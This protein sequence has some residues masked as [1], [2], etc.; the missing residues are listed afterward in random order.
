MYL[1]SSSSYS[2]LF[3]T[4]YTCV[5]YQVYAALS[6]VPNIRAYGKE[7]IPQ[8]FHYRGGKFVPPLML[9]A[10]PGWF[11]IEVKFTQRQIIFYL[12]QDIIEK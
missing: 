2:L 1:C 6:Q 12:F 7:E 9:L 3:K 10:D 5:L 4:L 8:R 11:I